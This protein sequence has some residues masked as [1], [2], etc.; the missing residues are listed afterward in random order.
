M[1]AEILD[2]PPSVR[3]K[4][5]AVDIHVA[6]PITGAAMAKDGD[7][8]WLGSGRAKFEVRL[9]GIDAPE[10]DQKCKDVAGEEW[11][12][13]TEATKALGSLVNGREIRCEVTDVD[14]VRAGRPIVKCLVGGVNISE[15][16]LRRGLAWAF[17][18]YLKGHPNYDQLKKLEAEAKASGLGVWRGEAEPPWEYRH[19]H[20]DRFAARA[21]GGCPIIGNEKS[22]IYH[23]PRS[24][25]YE[26]MF[27]AFIA[28]PNSKGKG[29]SAMK[30]RQLKKDFGLVAEFVSA[31]SAPLLGLYDPQQFQHVNAPLACGGSLNQFNFFGVW[32]V[33]LTAP[34]LRFCVP[35]QAYPQAWFRQQHSTPTRARFSLKPSPDAPFLEVLFECSNSEP[36]ELSEPGARQ[37]I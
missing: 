34:L 22:K 2:Q 28:N 17:E 12:C 26:R 23:T 9:H 24:R 20:W 15:E 7:S 37:P 8:A 36:E 27:E 32:E 10:H 1:A 14:A 18:K 35:A 11:P 6:R 19:N 4:M 16:M 31:A 3:W 5:Q 21:P 30:S 13:G 33:A 25:G 29:G